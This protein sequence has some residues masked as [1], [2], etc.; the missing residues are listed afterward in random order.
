MNYEDEDNDKKIKIPFKKVGDRLEFL[1]GGDIPIEDGCV[2]HLIVPI[3]EVIDQAFKN[4][5]LIESSVQVLPAGSLILIGMTNKSMAYKENPIYPV[6]YY[7]LTSGITYFE[8]VVLETPVIEAYRSN[9][10]NESSAKNEG[11][12]WLNLKGLDDCEIKSGP[13]KM[14]N[15]PEMNNAISLN[16]AYT[17]LSEKIESHRISHTGN[18]YKRCYYKE[19]NGKWYPLKLLRDN[20]K[21]DNEVSIIDASW[22]HFQNN[23]GWR[24]KKTKS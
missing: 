19:K 13:V 21:I 11:G 22:N 23:I 1:F 5:L 9:L 16:H 12:L 15:H 14:L 6:D 18:I 20:M 10:K 17:L 24:V 2:G 3:D 4:N 7:Y 8:P